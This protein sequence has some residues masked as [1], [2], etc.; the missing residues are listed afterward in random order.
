[1]KPKKEPLPQAELLAILRAADD[2]LAQGGPDLCIDC[3]ENPRRRRP[4][5]K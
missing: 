1:M 2:I 4:R 3:L 5:M